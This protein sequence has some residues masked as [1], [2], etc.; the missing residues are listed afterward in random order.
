MKGWNGKVLVAAVGLVLAF[1]LAGCIA[2]PLGEDEVEIDSANLDNG[3]Y[4]TRT[5]CTDCGCT[6]TDTACNCGT[7]PRDY[8][9]CCIDQGGDRTGCGYPTKRAAAA[10]SSFSGDSYSA[11]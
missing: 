1:G 10:S 3:G 4:T 7:P 2:P 9:L 5:V 6:A 11:R 8:K